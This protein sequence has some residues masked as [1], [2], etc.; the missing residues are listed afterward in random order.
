ML[1][2]C[3][4]ADVLS[5]WLPAD[6]ESA[7]E[8]GVLDEAPAVTMTTAAPLPPP[9]ITDTMATALV[10]A[11]PGTGSGT[12]SG[13]AELQLVQA[14]PRP[15][16]WPAGPALTARLR[17]L[18]A[19]YQRFTMRREPLPLRPDYLM[20]DGLVGMT[21]GGGGLQQQQHHQQQQHQQQQ[22]QQQQH[23]QF[24]HQHTHHSHHGGA[25]GPLAWQLGEELRRCS[26]VATETDPLFLEWQR[27]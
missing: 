4:C 19:A 21:M 8:P 9:L 27:R 12:G 17:R 26:V 7:G 23:Q 3:V 22:Q 16:T 18:V 10:M 14:G 11:T 13:V 6:S 20:H 2:R 25:G 1:Y 5:P 15:P 24:L